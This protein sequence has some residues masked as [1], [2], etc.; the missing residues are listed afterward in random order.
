M[1]VESLEIARHY[2]GP[3]TGRDPVSLQTAIEQL[4]R[5]PVANVL[6]ESKVDKVC[7]VKGWFARTSRISQVVSSADRA[8]QSSS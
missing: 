7:T 4:D 1:L 8:L 2:G 3:I 5:K 6:V